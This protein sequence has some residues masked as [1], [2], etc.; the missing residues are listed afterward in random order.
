MPT[1]QEAPDSTVANLSL[2]LACLQVQRQI[3]CE[4]KSESDVVT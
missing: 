3:I 4:R 1:A 2:A